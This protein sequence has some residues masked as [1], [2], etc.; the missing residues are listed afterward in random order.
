[1]KKLKAKVTL[2]L[3]VNVQKNRIRRSLKSLL[4]PL[5]KMKT[6]LRNKSFFA[7]ITLIITMLLSP[8][9]KPMGAATRRPWW[10]V[11]RLLRNPKVKAEV[12]KLKELIRS[13]L[14]I[15]VLDMLQYCLK[16][17]GADIGDY[18]KFG[19]VD[20]LVFDDKGPVKDTKTGEYLK[21]P[22]NCVT[23]GESEFLDTSV[24]TEVKQGKDG[25]S[26]KLADKKWASIQFFSQSMKHAAVIEY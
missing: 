20:R 11:A 21:E 1:M 8:T 25:V 7:F 22:V 12:D 2:L 18:V 6:L 5:R 19:A 16:V 17:V 24:I 26:I 4:S 13:E 10:K 23:L 3:K 14:D 9:L 15:K